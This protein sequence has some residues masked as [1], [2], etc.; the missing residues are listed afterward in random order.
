MNRNLQKI[1]IIKLSPLRLHSATSLHI[2]NSDNKILSSKP[3]VSLP[4][5]NLHSATSFVLPSA[6]IS[7]CFHNGP[8]VALSPLSNSL[9]RKYNI[10]QYS[11]SLGNHRMYPSISQCNSK[12]C[13]CCNYLSCNSTI[14][15]SI[16][17]R[18][19]SV[20][21]PFNID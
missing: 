2:P 19:F 17:N 18:V 11:P 9:I 7:N 12:R 1:P 4:R 3:V 10:K 14:K 15:S 8:R 21:L 20:N 6:N 13:R 16:N 5:L